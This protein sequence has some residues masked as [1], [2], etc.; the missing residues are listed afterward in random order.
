MTIE[1]KTKLE[2]DMALLLKAGKKA[3]EKKEFTKADKYFGECFTMVRTLEILGYK[4]NI[5]EY[6]HVANIECQ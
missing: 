1:Q 3:S 5:D 2:E 4:V 6:S